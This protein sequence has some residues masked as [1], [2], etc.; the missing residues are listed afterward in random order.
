MQFFKITNNFPRSVDWVLDFEVVSR[1]W[2]YTF[3]VFWENS[4]KD[5]EVILSHFIGDFVKDVNKLSVHWVF[6]HVE[7][8]WLQTLCNHVIPIQN[9]LR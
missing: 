4:L 6:A 1:H 9:L 5:W 8:W 7:G 2:S 3:V